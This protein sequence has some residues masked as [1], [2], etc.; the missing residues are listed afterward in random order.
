MP[1]LYPD[2]VEGPYTVP[3]G[4]DIAD[5]PQA[6]RDFADSLGGLSDVLEIVEITGDHTATAVEMGGLFT[7]SGMDSPTLTIV[8]DLAPVGSV[9]AMSNLSDAADSAVTVDTPNLTESVGQYAIMSFTQVAPNVWVPNGGAGG[10]SSALGG[11][12]APTITNPEG[13]TVIYFTAGAPGAAGP[14]LAYGAVIS[15]EGPTLTVEWDDPAVGGEVA[16][17]DTEPFTDYVVTVYG[18]NNAGRGEG[19]DTNPFQLNYNIVEST[20]TPYQVENY[21][22]T[23]KWYEVHEVKSTQDIVLVQSPKPYEVLLVGQGGGG[24]PVNGTSQ[25]GGGGGGGGGVLEHRNVEIDPGTYPVGVNTPHTSFNGWQANGGGGGAGGG[26][27]KGGVGGASGAPTTHSGG[28]VTGDWGGCGGG[29]AGGNGQNTTGNG[30]D[31]GYFGSGGG[32]GKASNVTGQNKTYAGGGNGGGHN[33]SGGNGGGFSGRNGALVIAYEIATPGTRVQQAARDRAAAVQAAY[34]SGMESGSTQAAELMKDLPVNRLLEEKPE[35]TPEP[36]PEP[37]APA[38]AL[39]SRTYLLNSDPS[40][41]PGLVYPST[42][43]IKLNR[44]DALVWQENVEDGVDILC[45]LL[46]DGGY[47]G[48]RRRYFNLYY[49]VPQTGSS[50]LKFY[51]GYDGSCPSYVD[52]PYTVT[53]YPAGQI[54]DDETLDGL[55]A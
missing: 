14:T 52:K 29:G 1:E 6:F 26:G 48:Y 44:E 28:T 4:T 20:A 7:Y 19:A 27:G 18:L 51:D 55:D 30:S 39:F 23:G 16:L 35:P 31:S 2:A 12:E 8:E 22:G 54:P 49:Y 17:S 53:A 33:N 50:K 45:E 3:S 10:G 37:E 46:P 41:E 11:P 21:N 43:Y 15:P 40:I 47:P 42:N 13:G 36:E 38:G 25:R 24:G 32:P 34:E 9:F 5:G